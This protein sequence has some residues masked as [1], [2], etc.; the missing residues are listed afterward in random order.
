MLPEPTLLPGAAVGVRR[1]SV[2][3]GGLTGVKLG[4]LGAGHDGAHAGLRGHSSHGVDLE[5]D[6]QECCWTTEA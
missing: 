4:P 5:S 3:V 6:K 1:P 2:V